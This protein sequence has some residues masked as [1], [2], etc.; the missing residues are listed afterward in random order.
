MV[1][2]AHARRMRITRVAAVDQQAT[3]DLNWRPNSLHPRF[4]GMAAHKKYH[5]LPS[6]QQRGHEM[7]IASDLLQQHIETLVDDNARWQMLIADEIL[8]EL[9]YAPSLGL[10]AQLWGRKEAVRHANLV[11]R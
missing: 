2:G 3:S 10:P 7:T 9:A 6:A 11:R 5:G 8:W 4:S 1:R